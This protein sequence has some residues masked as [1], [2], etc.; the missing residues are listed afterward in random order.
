E[1]ARGLL[2]ARLGDGLVQERLSGLARALLRERADLRAPLLELDPGLA[3]ERAV[4]QA[5]LD[6]V[7]VGRAEPERPE[8]LGDREPERVQ[9]LLVVV[10]EIAGGSRRLGVGLR[11]RAR[12]AARGRA[13]E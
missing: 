2:R 9:R 7:E 3:L 5:L 10:L 13:G 4:G 1:A 6:D 12:A 8:V 11:G